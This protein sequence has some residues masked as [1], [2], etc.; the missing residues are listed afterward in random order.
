MQNKFLLNLAAVRTQIVVDSANN[1]C[2]PLL[3]YYINGNVWAEKIRS[4]VEVIILLNPI[5][6]HKGVI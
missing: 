5:S 2:F 6:F 3:K 1:K 4:E